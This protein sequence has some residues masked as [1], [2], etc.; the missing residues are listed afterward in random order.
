MQW[1]RDAVG[2]G[3]PGSISG[4]FILSVSIVNLRYHKKRAWLKKVMSLYQ[5]YE[6]YYEGI[7]SRKIKINV[8]QDE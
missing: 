5:C 4:F 7:T 2:T 3:S 8:D 1:K 6:K